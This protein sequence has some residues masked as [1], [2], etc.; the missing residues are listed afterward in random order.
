M[1]VMTADRR[2]LLSPTVRRLL[3]AGRHSI[4]EASAAGDAR[5]RYAA[6]HLAAL[7][8]AA[9]ILADRARPSD[10]R[11]HRPRSAWSLLAGIA[12][13]LGEWAAYFA[14]GADKRAAAEAG[15]PA[16]VTG[17]EADDLLRAAATFLALVETTLGLLP[18]SS[19][20]RQG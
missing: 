5:E 4:D 11:S 17:R 16:A 8:A 6:A 13:E 15:R 18:S 10:S 2:R 1:S 9:A 3:A 12:P 7:R 19:A 14:A 20:S